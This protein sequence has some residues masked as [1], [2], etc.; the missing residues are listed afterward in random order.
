MTEV[1]WTIAVK[2]V[3]ILQLHTYLWVRTSPAG[4]KWGSNPH[5]SEIFIQVARNRL[6]CVGDVSEFFTSQALSLRHLRE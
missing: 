4:E 3:S 6:S 1:D 5:P 2:R